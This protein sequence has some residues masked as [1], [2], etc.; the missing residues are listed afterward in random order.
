M[1]LFPYGS[2]CESKIGE[3]WWWFYVLMGSFFM[4]LE[5]LEMTTWSQ[6]MPAVKISY[7]VAVCESCSCQP[8]LFLVI[9][10]VDINFWISW[11]WFHTPHLYG[12]CEWLNASGCDDRNFVCRLIQA[13]NND[14]VSFSTGEFG[15]GR[16]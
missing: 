1:L 6:R 11:T 8:H 10:F 14:H 9:N 13:K 15:L 12:N 16:Y 4:G 5:V 2:C 3:C 7:S